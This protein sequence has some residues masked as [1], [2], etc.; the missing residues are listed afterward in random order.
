MLQLRKLKQYALARGALNKWGRVACGLAANRPGEPIDAH[1]PVF[2]V[3]SSPKHT[4]RLAVLPYR[5]RISAHHPW[6]VTI[7]SPDRCPPSSSG[8]E[9]ETDVF[10]YASAKKA[11]D[12]DSACAESCAMSEYALLRLVSICAV[13]AQFAVAYAIWRGVTRFFDKHCLRVYTFTVL[14][15]YRVCTR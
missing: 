4:L 9:G 3:H 2:R 11:T 14:A 6:C 1:G 10:G 13:G 12:L 8:G 5:Q 15:F 7:R